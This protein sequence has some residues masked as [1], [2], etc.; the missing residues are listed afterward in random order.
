MFS[1]T[2]ESE[3]WWEADFLLYR[4]LPFAPKEWFKEILSVC[5]QNWTD[6]VDLEFLNGYWNALTPYTD[7]F[8]YY[9]LSDEIFP[10]NR[11]ENSSNIILGLRSVLLNHS[12]QYYVLFCLCSKGGCEHH[13]FWEWEW[14]GQILFPEIV[15]CQKVSKEILT[16]MSMSK[17]GKKSYSYPQIKVAA[18][19]EGSNSFME[20]DRKKQGCILYVSFLCCVNYRYFSWNIYSVVFTL[21]SYN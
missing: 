9:L 17:E 20:R 18:S 11:T 21:E 3:S 15:L 7:P 12:G 10:K 8:S 6:S 1:K 19:E 14:K 5:K 13:S 4:T 2:E 16:K